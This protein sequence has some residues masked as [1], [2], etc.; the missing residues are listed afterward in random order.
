[1]TRL[2]SIF[3]L[4]LYIFFLNCAK[5]NF[6]GTI[7]E[8]PVKRPV[9]I[10]AD[11]LVDTLREVA[12]IIPSIPETTQSVSATSFAYPAFKVKRNTV[13]VLLS[14]IHSTFPL[15]LSSTYTVYGSNDAKGQIEGKTYVN[16]K[17][18]EA[19]FSTL[20]DHFAMPI[21]LLPSVKGA[22]FKYDNQSY[23]GCLIIRKSASGGPI[24]INELPIEDYLKGV[25]PYEIG[26]RDSTCYEALKVQAIVAR[27]YTYSRLGSQDTSGFDVY[28]DES[29]QVY[30]GMAGEYP[31]S[32][33]AIDST[34]NVVVL[35][36]DSL[37]QTFYYST[38][39]G[40]TANIEEVWPDRG[41]RSYLRSVDDSV[42]NYSAKY[43]NWTEEWDGVSLEKIINKNL[44]G[45]TFGYSG[46]GRL[47][48]IEIESFTTCGRIKSL[49]VRMSG[50]TYHV[51]G[52]K[53][54]W[55]LRRNGPDKPIL[56]S[57][58]FTLDV[59]K[60]G[61]SIKKVRASGHGFGHGVG[62]S[63]IGAVGM[64]LSGKKAEEIINFYYTGV[65][66]A[67]VTY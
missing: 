25:V 22:S 16:I 21:L 46:K 2:F 1:M 57:A 56:R 54:R 9:P 17:G 60:N 43:F 50:D 33:K 20:P 52:D 65:T 34:R 30:N 19:V 24:I 27:T 55:L 18:T 53:V 6:V 3:P 35:A 44:P 29:D 40:K 59:I 26:K 67:V 37:I 28:S 51:F 64:A 62:M 10:H 41:Y 58:C 12:P 15:V 11:T 32:N 42:Y 13:R 7:E 39:S 63:Q 38:S 47:Q 48:N 45:L 5:T 4:V 36:N 23:R 66:L 61:T 8:K 31:L 49:A 14:S